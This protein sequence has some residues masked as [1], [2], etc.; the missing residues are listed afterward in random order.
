MSWRVL[1]IIVF[2]IIALAIGLWITSAKNSTRKIGGA[3]IK[4][5]HNPFSTVSVNNKIFK[6]F[7][8]GKEL[9]ITA[10][11]DSKD[12]VNIVYNNQTKRMT[13][14]GEVGNN[15]IWTVYIK[16]SPYSYMFKINDKYFGP[17]GSGDENSPQWLIEY[18]DDY[19]YYSEPRE[20]ITN[21]ALNT[22]SEGQS[23]R[24]I[25]TVYDKI[26]GGTSSKNK[27][28]QAI[29]II[30]YLDEGAYPVKLTNLE[31]QSMRNAG[32]L[33]AK[34]IALAKIKKYQKQS[35]KK[36]FTMNDV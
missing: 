31:I 22:E 25:N 7:Q 26:F 13:K 2:V 24:Y 27:K 20:S 12:P 23:D 8:E 19:I 30:K 29:K 10:E 16:E 35:G 18:G 33:S 1:L 34:N 4:F 17:N 32:I 14:L 9:Q 11:T 36:L 15:N 5:R 3:D 21:K 6:M 28:E